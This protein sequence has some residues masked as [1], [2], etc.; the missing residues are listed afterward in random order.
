LSLVSLIASSAFSNSAIAATFELTW[1]DNSSDETG[2]RVERKLGATGAYGVIVTTGA[3]VTSYNDSNLAD[4]T[5][6][7]YRVNAFNDAGN[8]PYS[9]EVCGTTPAATTRPPTQQFTLT[10][11]VVKTT[12]SSGTGNGTVVSTPAG[13]NCGATCSASFASGAIVTLTATPTTGS[14]FAG[15]SGTGCS[16]SVS[17]IVARTCT[18]TFTPPS[19]QTPTTYILS[20]AKTGNGTVT[21]TPTGINCGG[22]C[23]AAYPSGTLVT[24]KATA[25]TG[26]SF[27]GWSGSGCSGGVVTMNASNNCTATFQN[28]T[29]QLTTKFGV[30]RPD[31]GEWFLDRNGNGQWDGCTIDKCIGSFGQSADLP[32]TGSWSGNDVTNVGTFSPSTGSWRLDTNGDG[33]LDCAV[34]TCEDSFGQAGDFP[35]T[36]ELGDGNG[37]IVG[38][39]TPQTLTT[40]QNQGKTIKRGGWNFDV[41]GNS[42]LDGCEVDE[43]TT[44][45]ILGELPIVGDWNGT[46]TQDI[47]LFLPR[48]GSWYLDRNGNG[49]WDSC[50]KDKCFGPFG[51]E[52]DLPIIGDWDG[53]GTVRIGVFR[54]STGMWYLDI[55]GN[56]KMDSCTID[57]CFGP[58]GQP[59]DLPVV[60]KW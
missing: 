23:S 18:A 58:F 43:C 51:A 39:F 40:D 38:I 12:T 25:A 60:G 9:P 29:V 26:S 13:I 47:G 54:P 11:N 49:K 16:G 32:V 22:T 8:S 4:S 34:D 28:T 19:A 5:T 7:C 6:Y 46:G 53:T 31:T 59:G 37:S 2:F 30:F 42:T 17:M 3:N 48:K 56:G 35:V 52:G 57:G 44:F 21:S 27:N 20:V 50:E 41:N 33:V 24:L 10:V 36:R 45:R 15:W 14:T 1:A 55:N